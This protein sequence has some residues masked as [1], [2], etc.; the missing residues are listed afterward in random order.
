MFR[1]RTEL[2]EVGLKYQT[3]KAYYHLFTEFYN[4]FFEKRRYESLEILEIGIDKGSS[5][6][7]LEEYFPHATIHC[8]D[9]VE[10]SVNLKFGERV[11][12]YLCSQD[13]IPK[14]KQIFAN[15][16]FDIIIEDGSHITSH[17]QIDLGFLIPYLKPKGIYIC[18]DMH[19]SYHKNYIDTT[20]TTIEIVERF[21]KTKEMRCDRMK[22]DEKRYIEEN[23][24][25]VFMYERNENALLCWNCKN[26]NHFN[27]EN[28]L[29][30]QTDISPNDKS[31][32]SVLIHK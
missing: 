14:M 6:R 1:G 24:E 17:Q 30:C 20:E 26:Q 31:I 28:C 12:T 15:K 19:T 23:I 7:M 32:T 5:I 11:H 13:D 2:T 29:Y 3:D 25:D 16:K 4:S 10:E 18:E 21:Q 22:E 27:R 8:I 9:I